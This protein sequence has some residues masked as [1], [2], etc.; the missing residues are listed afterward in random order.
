M[1]HQLLFGV[2]RWCS[3]LPEQNEENPGV[4]WSSEQGLEPQAAKP[5]L[6]FMP[7]MQRRRLSPLAKTVFH[8]LNRCTTP[9][10]QDPV[11]F[12]SKYGESKRTFGILEDISQT[13]AVSPMAFSLSVHNAIA[14]QWSIARKNKAPMISLAPGQY[15]LTPA[16]LEAC[17]MLA[18]Q[19]CQAVNVV[20]YEEKLPDFYQPYAKSPEHPSCLTLRIVPF[21][22]A[23]FNDEK[24]NIL[25]FKINQAENSSTPTIDPSLTLVQQ[26]L[27]G[28]QQ[29]VYCGG[30]PSSWIWS[31]A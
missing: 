28:H 17:G 30:A 20:F 22:A 14:G 6:E 1:D 15:G 21:D 11:I 8:T 27:E 2:E 3:W 7:M 31:H 25:A 16:L 10:S 23:V 13:E 26:L 12:S 9:S 24:K 4:F 29:Q 19:Q 5:N 18:L